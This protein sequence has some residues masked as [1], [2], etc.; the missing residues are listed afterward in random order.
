MVHG[1]IHVQGAGRFVSCTRMLS[2]SFPPLNARRL[3]IRSILCCSIADGRG[4]AY[5]ALFC[6]VQI[7]EKSTSL[8]IR[9]SG[10]HRRGVDTPCFLI[11]AL[12]SA[13]AYA[14]PLNIVTRRNQ[15]R[16][17]CWFISTLAYT[18]WAGFGSRH[19]GGHGLWMDT[20]RWEKC[21]LYRIRTCY[22]NFAS[23]YQHR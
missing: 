4:S 18:G 10:E 12:R 5:T 21:R 14:S 11:C 7:E 6:W 19:L 13:G 23:T 16:R 8:D 9:G 2:V 22:V 3:P 20:H 17:R 1:G 15:L